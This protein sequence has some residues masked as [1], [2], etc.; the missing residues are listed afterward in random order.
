MERQNFFAHMSIKR[1]K[2][3]IKAWCRNVIYVLEDDNS[4]LE[5]VVYTLNHSGLEAKGF[6]KPSAFWKEMDSLPD[7]LLLDLMLPEEDGLKILKK[8][9][10]DKQTRKLPVIILTA[11]SSEYDKVVGLDYGAD[12]YVTKPFGMMELVARVNALLRRTK[13][14]TCTGEE[15]RIG[16]LVVSL[17]KHIVK[18]KGEHVTLTSKEFELLAMFVENPSVV[19]SRDQIL[20]RIW[21]YEF[22]GANRTVD[23]HIGT[24][25]QKLGECGEYIRTVRGYGYKFIGVET[26]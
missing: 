16:E 13:E 15:F 26:E 3:K 4:I 12:D 20:N 11:K 22:D 2:K 24:L 14:D 19:F 10:N 7:L 23:V 25:R 6:S 18:V 21:G 9:R 17:K 1:T 5:L 8:L